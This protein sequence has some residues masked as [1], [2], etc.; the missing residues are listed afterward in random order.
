MFDE[1]TIN[2]NYHISTVTAA[3]NYIKQRNE[4]VKLRHAV[5]KE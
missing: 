3:Y 5:D 4:A 2:I 1:L